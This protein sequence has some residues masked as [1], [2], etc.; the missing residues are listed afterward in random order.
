[1]PWS[2]ADF[3]ALVTQLRKAQR[4]YYRERRKATPEQGQLLLNRAL[5][6]EHQVDDALEEIASH[7]PLFDHDEHPV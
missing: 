5:W 6:L 2:L 3:S 1:M 7:L 4:T